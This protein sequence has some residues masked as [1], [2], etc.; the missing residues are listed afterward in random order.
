MQ[1][2]ASDKGIRLLC[3]VLFLA[4][5]FSWTYFFQAGL[6]ENAY[7]TF[8]GKTGIRIPYNRLAMSLVLVLVSMLLTLP[9]RKI[10]FFKNG[11]LACHYILPA[12]FL[13]VVTSFNQ[14]ARAWIIAAVFVVLLAVVC[15][16]VVSVPKPDIPER[17][18]SGAILIMVMLFILVAIIGNT[19]ENLHRQ[20]LIERY[21]AKGD[22]ESALMVGRYEE[23][24][25]ESIDMLRAKA[26]IATGQAGDELFQYSICN[27]SALADSLDNELSLLL[28][29]DVMTFSNT[30]DLSS[31]SN[32]P[33]YFMQA[34][35]LAGDQR[36]QEIYPE[37]Y[38][39]AS[40]LYNKF[41]NALESVKDFP[42][43]YQANS[44]FI[45]YHETYYWFYYFKLQQ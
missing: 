39:D 2:T 11:T 45:T 25:D 35:V 43:Q 20:L 10:R 28:R 7:S 33:K 17:A 37:Q 30:L 27:P 12:I 6:L 9:S 4:F 23:E 8:A 14:S 31:Y 5:A 34:M 13:G 3:A 16:I 1:N 19:D 22:Y 40:D 29:G 24:S 36:V 41:L 26:L 18:F 32:L 44:T 15:R 38:S 21:M 42:R